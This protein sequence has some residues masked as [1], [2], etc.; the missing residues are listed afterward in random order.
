MSEP[1]QDAFTWEAKTD[2]DW[3]FLFGPEYKQPE[4]TPAVTVTVSRVDVETQT[5]YLE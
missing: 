5:I 3:Q 1:L 4:P 2:E